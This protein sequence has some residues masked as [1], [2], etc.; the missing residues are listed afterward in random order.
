MVVG[1]VAYMSPEQARGF[2][3]D[4]RS[5][6]WSFGCLLY[7]ALT[8]RRL[9][10]G[11]TH[12][13]LIAGI[14]RDDLKLDLLPE[15]MPPAIRRLLPVACGTNLRSGSGTSAMRASKSRMLSRRS[16]KRRVRTG[17]VGGSLER[18]RPPWQLLRC[19]F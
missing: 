13:D 6:I 2:P 1:T 14:L 7:E 8:G 4:K 19:V 3:L 12:S 15:S 9:S 5:D 16:L 18:Q 10:T 17:V 11:R